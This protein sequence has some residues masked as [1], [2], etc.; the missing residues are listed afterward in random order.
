MNTIELN[1][2]EFK[3]LQTNKVFV[4]NGVIIKLKVKNIDKSK[5]YG[6]N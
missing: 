2:I 1:E 3:N 6:N 4:K 5:M